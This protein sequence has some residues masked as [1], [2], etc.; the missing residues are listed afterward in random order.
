MIPFSDSILPHFNFLAQMPPFENEP[1]EAPIPKLAFLNFKRN[2][3]KPCEPSPPCSVFGAE[4]AE[5]QIHSHH[6]A[7]AKS[8]VSKPK[9]AQA[10]LPFQNEFEEGSTRSVKQPKVTTTHHTQPSL[11]GAESEEAVDEL[12]WAS[13]SDGDEA[14]FHGSEKT[15]YSLGWDSLV[16]FKRGTAF[17]EDKEKQLPKSKRK[18]DNSKR[19]SEAAYA[20]KNAE[21]TFKKN[22]TDSSRLQKLF[23]QSTC[24][25]AWLH[26][27]FLKTLLYI[28]ISCFLDLTFF[29]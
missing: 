3:P 19:E 12:G 17:K 2:S 27:F 13:G 15:V 24:L 10:F 21:F 6:V 8:V 1:E 20:R 16:N 14:D 7:K 4:P 23:D 9:V 28:C 11:F 5:R 22:G 26:C 29:Y 25:C 18:Y